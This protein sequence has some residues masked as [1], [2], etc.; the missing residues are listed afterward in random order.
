MK[1]VVLGLSDGVDSAVAA[2][3]LKREG[4]EVIGVHLIMADDKGAEAAENSAREIGIAFE[5]LDIRSELQNKVC[6]HF[7][8]EYLAGRTPSPCTGCNRDVKLPALEKAMIKLDANAFATGHYVLKRDNRLFMGDASCDQSYMLAKLLPHQVSKLLLPLGAYSKTEI[9]A[10]AQENSLSCASK[11]DSRENCFIKDMNYMD[12]IA[13]CRPNDIPPCGNVLYK[14]SII[15][16]HQGIHRYT[17]GQRWHEDIGDRRA[18]IKRIDKQANTVELCLWD[19]L[20][21]NEVY[22]SDLSWIGG[23]APASE[24]DGA[25]RVRHTR[26]ETPQSHFEVNNTFAKV[27]TASSLRAPAPG[28]TA[29]IYIDNELMGGGDVETEVQQ[30]LFDKLL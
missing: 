28:Q 11:P 22:V 6:E 10:I 3:M 4:Y 21:T 20:F 27:T 9:R 17:V 18:Y 30:G 29:A 7:V 15:A 8:S 14:G 12:Y 25:I 13:A 24:F 1:K 26:W 2:L 16:T 23:N 19:E 5:A